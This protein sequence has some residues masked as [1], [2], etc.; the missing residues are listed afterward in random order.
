MHY[1]FALKLAAAV[2]DNGSGA[3]DLA[4]RLSSA[5]CAD[6]RVEFGRRDRLTLHFTR[7]ASSAQGAILSAVKDVR[8][9]LPECRLLDVTPDFMGLTDMA[10]LVGV[11][12]QNLRQLMIHHEATFPA[13]IH[14]GNSALWHLYPVLAWLQEQADYSVPPSLLEVAQVAMQVNL[15]REAKQIQRAT[16]QEFSALLGY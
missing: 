16:Q 15:A 13:A 8:T 7:E 9:A 14:E 6:A 5:G 10:K 11:T 3:E 1:E 2:G 4:G 12:R